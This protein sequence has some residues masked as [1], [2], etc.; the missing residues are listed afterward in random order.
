MRSIIGMAA[1]ACLVVGLSGGRASADFTYQ[2]S[3]A[4]FE[5]GGTLTGTF[6]TNTAL[7]TL[8][9]A[10]I[11]TSAGSN[12]S[13]T[14]SQVSYVYPGAQEF[15]G[16]SYL[17]LMQG[18]NIL[19]LSFGAGLNTTGSTA[20]QVG[21]GSGEGQGANFRYVTAGTV[22]VSFITPSAVPEPATLTLL[23]C[24]IPAALGLVRRRR[25][26]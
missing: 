3:G 9:S 16:P 12:G 23:A 10:S 2:F 1:A 15:F 21:G 20:I 11:T 22:V 7:T 8:L 13:Q 17:T 6:T 24:G 25:R 26:G 19:E 18:A 14:F 4:T 5:G